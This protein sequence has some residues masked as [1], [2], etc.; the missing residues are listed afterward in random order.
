MSLVYDSL[1]GAVEVEKP[2]PELITSRLLRRLEG[3]SQYGFPDDMY[4][5]KGFTRFEHSVGVM[6]LLHNL[7]ADLETRIAGLLHDVSHT[8]FSHVIDWVFDNEVAEDYQDKNHKHVIMNDSEISR[9]LADYSIP[10]ERVANPENYPLLEQKAPWLCADRIDYT[11]REL[12]Y[13]GKREDAKNLVKSI[14][15]KEDR[16]VFSSKDAAWRFGRYYM[17]R[18]TQHWGGSE[19]VVR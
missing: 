6:V 19:A 15:R 13:L 3:V 10:S 2:F 12:Y 1:Y 11:L 17:Q 5:I 9:I 7:K 4:H 8:A 14:R 18:Q 16:V